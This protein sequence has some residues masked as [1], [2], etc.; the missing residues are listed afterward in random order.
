VNDVVISAHGL[1][2]QYRIWTQS[3]PQSLSDRVSLALHRRRRDARDAPLR[4]EI[5]A[6]R[7][8]SFDVRR[9]E[10]LGIIGPNGAGKS[11]LL[12]VLARITD[13]TEGHAELRGRVSSL[14][15]VG[16]GF[17]PE[18]SGRDNVFLNGAILG[19]S[20][21][22]TAKRFDEIV[23][24][25]G[26]RDFIDVPVKR[27]SSGMYIRL[28]FSVAAHLDPE[29]LLLDEV[30]AVGDRAFQAKCLARIGEM[31]ENGKAVVF[32]SHDVASVA[33][34]CNRGLVLSG[35]HVAFLGE[36]DEAVATYLA[37]THVGA[38]S[39]EAPRE[40]SGE[41]RIT[42]ISVTNDRGSTGIAPDS[43][44]AI[45]VGMRADRHVPR[46]HLRLQLG[47]H[48]TLGGL[49]VQLSTDFDPSRPLDRADLE[50]GAVIVCHVDNLP[51]KP[52]TYVI[53]ATLERAGGDII[54]RIA[55]QAL[56]VIVPADFYG[57]GVVAGE[58]HPAPLLVRHHWDVLPAE[59]TAV[60]A[61]LNEAIG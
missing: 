35:G 59:A 2:K 25:S 5:W 19:M 38:D 6:L 13:P 24:F 61:A 15:E 49:F 39:E 40:G 10:V 17:H 34:L 56:F 21:A 31:V 20:R 47:I 37:S 3:R 52:G 30:L 50:G 22:D 18:L 41:L 44:V 12:S 23:E 58:T 27:Y 36:I 60:A 43:P 46:E 9:G 26:V 54:D 29:I 8:V 14:L 51:L 4:R 28:A 33:H 45:R 11:T 16:T 53:S 48:S 32:V 7:D 42:E 1:G 57:T 55:N